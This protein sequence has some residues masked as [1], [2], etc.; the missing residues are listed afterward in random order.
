MAV[1]VRIRIFVSRAPQFVFR[2]RF[3]P[4]ALGYNNLFLF[5]ALDLDRT[6]KISGTAGVWKV[7]GSEGLDVQP[8]RGRAGVAALFATTGLR[9]PA[10]YLM[11][12]P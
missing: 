1:V 3:V 8:E 4:I 5:S 10:R 11:A 12:L 9:P 7:Q 6:E 2:F